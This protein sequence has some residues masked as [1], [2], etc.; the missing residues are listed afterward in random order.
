[1]DLS[2][3][4][5]LELENLS[6]TCKPATFG[7]DQKDVLDESYRNARKLDIADFATTFELRKS[8]IMD[9]VRAALLQGH[10]SNTPVEAELYKLNVYSEGG[11]FKSHR[12]TPRNGTMFASLVVVFPVAHA[13]GALQL[14]HGGNEWTVDPVTATAVDNDTGPVISYIAFYS[15]V[16]HEVTLVT[17][18][19]RVTLTWN[20]YFQPAVD[21]PDYSLSMLNPLV[22]PKSSESELALKA[23]LTRALSDSNFLPKGGHLGFGLCQEYP[24]NPDL[25]L[26]NLDD[27]LKG[28]DAVIQNVCRQLALKTSLRIVYQRQPEEGHEDDSAMIDHF[29]NFPRWEPIEVLGYEVKREG[30]RYIDEPKPVTI[31]GYHYYASDDFNLVWVTDLTEYTRAKTAYYMV[32]GNEPCLGYAYCTVCLIV[33]IGPFGNRTANIEQPMKA[34]N[35]YY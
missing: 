21:L 33:H 18:G 22:H 7:V 29:F 3:A 11:F 31:E 6:S 35:R 20:L 25:G 24:I 2:Q 10:D 14:R 4:S 32:Y 19:Y 27:Y 5:K 17:S 34:K 13:G 9:V 8:G 16:E 23:A 28:S 30:G 15:D 26:G 1:I 12:D